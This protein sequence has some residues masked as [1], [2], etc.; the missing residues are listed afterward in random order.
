MSADV[1]IRGGTV[2]DGTGAPGYRADVA[3]TDGVISEI[4]A[5]LDGRTDLDA[6][7]QVVA[8]GFIDV[9]THYDAQ[10]FWDPALTPSSW[11]GVTTVV[12]GNCGFTL[13]PCRPENREL[14]VRTLEHVEDMSFDDAR[15]RRAVGFRD[16]PRVPRLHRAAWHGTQL[17][18]LRRAHGGAALGDGRGRVRACCARRRDRGDAARRPRSAGARCG[19]VRHQLGADAR[20]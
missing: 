13:A 9:H 14:L 19:R 18:V 11:H 1:V 2:I 8:P 5:K 6:T 10:V 17:H 4:G 20:G 12:A 16:V 3:V 7:D 15:R